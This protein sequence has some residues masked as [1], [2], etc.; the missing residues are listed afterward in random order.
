M[1]AGGFG[2]VSAEPHAKDRFLARIHTRGNAGL[3]ERLSIACLL[4]DGAIVTAA[5][6]LSFW[7]RFH[8]ALA[9]YGVKATVTFESYTGYFAVGAFLLLLVFNH[10]RLYEKEILLR[11]R[12]ACWLVLKSVAVWVTLLL[13]GALVFEF[14]PQISRTFVAL[15]AVTAG[16]GLF[17]WRSAFHGYLRSSPLAG[18]LRQ[19]VIFIGWNRDAERLAQTFQADDSCS[20]HMVGCIAS[21]RGRFQRK[22]RRGIPVLGNIQDL[23]DLLFRH[24][25]DIVMLTDSGC[26]RT[27]VISI[28][29]TCE[30][31]MVQFKVI[32]SYFE[33]LVSGLHLE[34]VSGVPVLGVAQLPFDLL[35]NRLLKRAVDLC[36][37]VVGLILSAPIIAIAG[38]I[39]YLESPGPIFYRQRRLGRGGVVFDIIKIRS[40]RLDAEKDGKVGWSKMDDPRRLR[41]GA[42]LRRWNLDEVPQFWNVLTGEMSLVGPRP[43][44]PELIRDFKEEI[45]HYNARHNA[46]PGITGWAQVKGLRGDTDL[47]ERIKCDLWYLENWSLLLD[48]QIILM[49]FATRANEDSKAKTPKAAA[50]TEQPER[51]K[52]TVRMAGKIQS[53]IRK[54]PS[55]IP[56]PW[57]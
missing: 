18:R 8:T 41:C 33:I 51:P 16:A 9:N 44:R 3:S 25:I 27:E 20:Y 22:P 43:E 24:V 1:M 10:Y 31:E 34:T 5:M 56:S 2:P 4:C 45:P 11:H 23:E 46:K 38:A 55:V 42:F 21:S 30:K 39:V 50:P 12:H 26:L 29:N 52:S 37:A 54:P 53:G 13:G 32:P 47:T 6:I 40:M 49:T 36:G 19:N 15:T 28:A 7:L 35:P 17:A 57:K 14:S 48:L